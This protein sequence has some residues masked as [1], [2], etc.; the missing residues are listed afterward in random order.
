M[1]CVADQNKKATAT[2]NGGTSK[3]LDLVRHRKPLFFI[4]RL[5]FN[6]LVDDIGYS[7]IAI[8]MKTILMFLLGAGMF[9][10]DEATMLAADSDALEQRTESFTIRLNGSV[11]EVTPLFGP[12]REAEW[13]PSWKPRFIHPIGGAQREGTIF[14]TITSNGRERLWVLTAYDANEGRVEYVLVAPDFSINEIC[15]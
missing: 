4:Q 3:L 13:A 11:A 6:D 9:L 12:V 15:V 1:H 10:S 14:R 7:D 2:E 5:D 8:S